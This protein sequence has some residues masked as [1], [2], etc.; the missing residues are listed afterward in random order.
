[1]TDNFF[2]NSRK[3]RVSVELDLTNYATKDDLKGATGI[4]TASFVKKND[5]DKYLDKTTI[6]NDYYDKKTVDHDFMLK[7]TVLNDYMDKKTIENDYLNKNKIESDYLNKST[8]QS[9]YA[10]KTELSNTKTNLK[11]QIAT[12]VD[13][14]KL[15]VKKLETDF[16]SLQSQALTFVKKTE[17]DLLEQEHAASAIE[18]STLK[19]GVSMYEKRCTDNTNLNKSLIQKNTSEINKFKAASGISEEIVKLHQTLTARMH[20]TG[21][22]GMQNYL[23]YP[24]STK[25]IGPYLVDSVKGIEWKSTGMSDK[26]LKSLVKHQPTKKELDNGTDALEFNNSI[27]VVYGVDKVNSGIANFYLVYELDD[28]TPTSGNGFDIKNCLFGAVSKTLRGRGIAF[29]SK[30]EWTHDDGNFARNVIVFGAKSREG[31]NSGNGYIVLGNGTTK[32]N[33]RETKVDGN[34]SVNFTKPKTKFCLSVHYNGVNSSIF[35]NGKKAYKFEAQIGLPINTPP[36]NLYLGSISLFNDNKIK[37]VG[38][39]GGVYEFGLDYRALNDTE[40]EKIHTYL[41]KKHGI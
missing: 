19:N 18:I 29:D 4:D 1:M 21:D 38:L 2:E 22:D 11:S 26:S 16:L 6:Q 24:P 37:D 12:S 36:D 39:N 15:S 33:R 10:S 25:L 9:S 41:M 3:N 35:V 31:A 5:M 34:F 13:P 32:I 28:W 20:F 27:M 17:F 7:N 8:I 30:D 14:V 40:I 23:I